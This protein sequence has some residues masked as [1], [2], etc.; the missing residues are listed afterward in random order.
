[1]LASKH[2]G[3]EIKILCMCIKSLQSFLTLC[4]PMDCGPPG[5]SVH[6]DCLGK[7]TEVSCHA[8]LQ[9][10]FPTW[11]SNLH[12]LCLL[13]WQ[14]GYL[15]LAPPGKPR[16]YCTSVLLYSMQ[17]CMAKYTRAH[18]LSRMSTCD[19]D[20]VSQTRELIC[21]ILDTWTFWTGSRLW[22][23]TT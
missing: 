12:P 16:R 2:P 23:F 21:I 11:G 10:I 1:M 9:G 19:N 20:H 6:W 4:N 13:H 14:A 22:K 5:S 15:P 3:L 17:Y 8:L 7:N 18:H